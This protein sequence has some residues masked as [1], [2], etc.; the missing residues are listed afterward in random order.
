MP[1]GGKRPGAG[2]PKGSKTKRKAATCAK[3]EAEGLTPAQVMERAMLNHARAGRWDKAAA[4]AKDLAPYVHPRLASVQHGGS[5]GV[6]LEIVEEI[7]EPP[8]PA[9][10]DGAAAPG[11]A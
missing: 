11:P 10:P 2:R 3:A 4:I 1:R 7:L 6:Q 5:V 9:T 8:H